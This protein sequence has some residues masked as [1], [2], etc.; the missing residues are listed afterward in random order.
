MI[1][2]VFRVCSLPPMRWLAEQIPLDILGPA[3]NT[4]RKRWKALSKPTKRAGLGKTDFVTE[5]AERIGVD[6]PF[7]PVPD[8]APLPDKIAAEVRHWLRRD[9]TLQDVGRH[10][11][12]TEHYDDINAETHSYFRRFTDG[13]RI[14]GD[15]LKDDAKVLDITCR[16][17]NGTLYFWEHG[18]VGESVCV[19]PSPRMREALKQHVAAS[20]FP[21]DKYRWVQMTEERLP[22]PNETFET[23][24]CFETLEHLADPETFVGELARVTKPG[25]VAVI[26]TPNL[27]WEPVHALAA[28]TGLHHSE[29]PHRF[30]RRRDLR[31]M[32]LNSGFDLLEEETTVLIPSGPQWLVEVGNWIERH[33]RKTLMPHLG[34][35]RILVCR[36]R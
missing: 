17:G 12:A 7:T 16:T 29:G 23:V 13:L 36:R 21:P 11:D 4:A 34:L 6:L 26:T 14:A 28:V 19:D 31:R 1:S 20:D 9:W 22:L 2:G 32:V 24:L 30:L 18:K 8:E 25:G 27:L 35:R 15:Y 5:P 3:F 33:T 10:W